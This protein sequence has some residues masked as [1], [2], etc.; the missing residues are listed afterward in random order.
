M[1]DS[2]VL[3]RLKLSNGE[4]Y[5][6]REKGTGDKL[7][8]LIHGN[9]SSSLFWDVLMDELPGDEYRII[10]PDLR[11]FG[12]STYHK[13]IVTINDFSQDLK[14]FVDTLG[15]KTFVL[16]GWSL[17]GL[18]AEQF[19]ANYQEYVSKLVLIAS[20]T[21]AAVVPKFDAN[22]KA[23]PGEFLTTRED[24]E[25]RNADILKTLAD[26]DYTKLEFGMNMVIFNNNK[27]EPVRYKRYL[28]AVFQQRNKVD[29][30]YAV[31][32]FNITNEH[33]G[34]TNGTGEV[35]KITC[36]TLVLQGGKDLV[37]PRI[38][39]EN[40]AAEIGDN[41]KLVILPN[42]GHSPFADCLDE[43]LEAVTAFIAN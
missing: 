18:V 21:K 40:I 12:D 17:G 16:V 36:P 4:T 2:I 25:L 15:L 33:N 5:A 43:L 42:S 1:K 31:L 34:I 26:H 27:P 14:S 38:C 7:L 11:G 3:K 10:A 28:D 20:T 6:Y 30:D 9:M 22:G 39:G 41:A 24:L 8:V 35:D 37:V 19:T 13:P 32:Q 29:V 23:I